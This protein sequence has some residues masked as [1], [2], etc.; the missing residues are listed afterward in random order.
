MYN[1]VAHI[2]N[3]IFTYWNNTVG[4]YGLST[5]VK[6]KGLQYS[7]GTTN[8]QTTF[9][10]Q[11]PQKQLLFPAPSTRPAIMCPFCAQD[12]MLRQLSTHSRLT[13]FYANERRY[14][15]EEVMYFDIL[16]S[17]CVAQIHTLS[18][19]K[20]TLSSLCASLLCIIIVNV[21]AHLSHHQ[22]E[23]NTRKTRKKPLRYILP[24]M[25]N[26]CMYRIL[27]QVLCI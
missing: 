8:K 26:Y 23:Q 24:R 27:Q 17:L 1:L 3:R 16:H 14:F 25:C 21:S 12:R 13:H 19:L 2:C 20:L 15:N 5:E 11:H 9:E 4:G 18:A 7:Y 6:G 10:Y 22:G